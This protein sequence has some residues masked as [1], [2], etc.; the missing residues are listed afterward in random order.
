[1]FVLM[2]DEQLAFAVVALMSRAQ[3]CG[4]QTR[5]TSA[6]STEI[7]ITLTPQDWPEPRWDLSGDLE[8]IR[9]AAHRR[10]SRETRDSPGFE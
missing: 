10:I 5:L 9:T 8:E 1:M 4:W 3:Q 6:K 2:I 7:V